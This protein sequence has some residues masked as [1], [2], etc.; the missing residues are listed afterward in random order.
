MIFVIVRDD[1]VDSNAKVTGLDL[2]LGTLTTDGKDTSLPLNLL[3]WSGEVNTSAALGVG[4]VTVTSGI[5]PTG[6]VV[7]L[8]ETGP[9]SGVFRAKINLIAGVSVP[10]TGTNLPSLRVNTSDTLRMTYSDGTT[11]ARIA[12][13]SSIRIETTPPSFANFDPAEAYATTNNLPTVKADATDGDSGV[14]DTSVEVIWA[15][16]ISPSDEAIERRAGHF[17]GCRAGRHDHRGRSKPRAALP[18]C[19]R[20]EYRPR[21]L[22]VGEGHG[23]GR[24]HR[25]QRPASTFFRHLHDRLP[26]HL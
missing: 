3:F 8:T 22:L 21:H 20:P 13:T 4:S 7:T 15:V 16:D 12:R 5:D 24:Q 1:L 6:F 14:V 2:G 26:G 19:A 9:S 11:A 25:N 18:K 10:G 17:R 23:R